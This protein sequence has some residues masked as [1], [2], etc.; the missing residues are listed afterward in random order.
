[1]QMATVRKITATGKGTPYVT[2][3]R[4]LLESLGWRKRQKVEVRRARGGIFI[5]DARRN[6]RS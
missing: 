5:R 4:D 3:P 1:M 2:F 6:K